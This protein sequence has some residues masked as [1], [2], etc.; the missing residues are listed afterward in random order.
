[1]HNASA[2]SRLAKYSH[3]VWI[4]TEEMD[5]LLNPLKSESLV[6]ESGIGGTA[7]LECR[8]AGETKGTKSVVHG[9][10]DDASGVVVLAASEESRRVARVRLGTS[11]VTA[12]IDPDQNRC[13]VTTVSGIENS[14]WNDYVQEQAVLGCPWAVR[15]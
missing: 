2:T 11:S 14:F 8:S 15:S 12:T 3:S 4:A 13:T 1:M 10:V 9:D 7:L 5:V 6:Q